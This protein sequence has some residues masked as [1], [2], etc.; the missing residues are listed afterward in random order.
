MA[1]KFTPKSSHLTG[2]EYDPATR[3]LLV[4]F[5][6]GSRHLHSGVPQEAYDNFAKY[7]SAGQFYHYLAKLH[8]GTK[9]K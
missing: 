3:A 4:T 9:L 1:M 2:V 8:P 5:K 6:N 7:R